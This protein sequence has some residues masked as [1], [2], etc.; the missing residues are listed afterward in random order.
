M[1]MTD[2][3]DNIAWYVEEKYKF[4]LQCSQRGELLKSAWLYPPDLVML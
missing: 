4:V 1:E 3:Q 2:F